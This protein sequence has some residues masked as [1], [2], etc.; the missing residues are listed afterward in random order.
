M[1]SVFVCRSLVAN[2]DLICFYQMR[3][4]QVP[5]EGLDTEIFSVREGGREN[6]IRAISWAT[7]E[8]FSPKAKKGTKRPFDRRRYFRLM[9]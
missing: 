2:G 8:K 1:S 3:W 5:W 4:R 6:E 9:T 7:S